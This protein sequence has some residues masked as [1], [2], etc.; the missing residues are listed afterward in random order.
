MDD[1]ENH[2]FGF[3]IEYGGELTYCE[4][5]MRDVGYDIYLN[6]E[7]KASIAHTD[8]F[9]WIQASGA[10]LPQE[11]IDEIGFRIEDKYK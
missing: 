3:A 11:I 1:K 7:W 10:I 4:V 2:A 9:T 8:D 5:L 6:N